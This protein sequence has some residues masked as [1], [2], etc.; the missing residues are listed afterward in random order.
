M[1]PV[2]NAETPPLFL[3]ILC[4]EVGPFTE[5]GASSS[6]RLADQQAPGIPLSS[7]PWMFLY[8]LLF[9]FLFLHIYLSVYLS[10]LIFFLG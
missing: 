6:T 9:D 10:L 8:T 4:F 5:T 3:F 2:V 1:K 7:T